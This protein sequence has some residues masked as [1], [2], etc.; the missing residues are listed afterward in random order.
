MWASV[1]N[2]MVETMYRLLSMFRVYWWAK[3]LRLGS[4]K[5]RGGKGN[6]T[7]ANES[8]RLLL[9]HRIGLSAIKMVVK[10]SGDADRHFLMMMLLFRLA[11]KIV[12]KSLPTMIWQTTSSD[13]DRLPLYNLPYSSIGKPGAYFRYPTQRATGEQIPPGIMRCGVN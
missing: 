11:G 1:S 2:C 13:V 10:C 8:I 9:R 3:V 7:K 12:L 4:T 5:V 6:K